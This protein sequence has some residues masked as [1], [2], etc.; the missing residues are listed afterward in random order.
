MISFNTP[1][2]IAENFE[3]MRKAQVESVRQ[4]LTK[5]FEPVKR[6]TKKKNVIGFKLEE[7][8]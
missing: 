4:Q 3:T 2:G 5:Q 8:K 6:S 7:E 1:E